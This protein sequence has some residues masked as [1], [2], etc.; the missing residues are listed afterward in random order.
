MLAIVLFAVRR[1]IKNRNDHNTTS[2]DKNKNKKEVSEENTDDQDQEDV[3][4]SVTPPHHE[5]SDKLVQIEAGPWH[6]QGDV[7][8]G[9]IKTR[10]EDLQYKCVQG[11]N[12][13]PV[14]RKGRRFKI[15]N[16][17]EG[18]WVFSLSADAG[19]TWIRFGS[20]SSRGGTYG[21]PSATLDSD[22]PFFME[23][24]VDDDF[25]FG[26]EGPDGMPPD[27]KYFYCEARL[28]SKFDT[29]Y[30]AIPLIDGKGIPG[31]ITALGSTEKLS[32]SGLTPGSSYKLQ[33]K[34]FDSTRVPWQTFA[35]FHV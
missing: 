16:L 3:P 21:G 28:T 30:R 32:F 4:K 25:E 10:L 29:K 8:S 33:H 9:Y 1:R 5:P 2:E 24:V 13:A 12:S 14:T 27:G 35:T 34:L 6:V 20:V 31:E 19:H 7:W 22:A 23:D 17:T 26:P 18:S 15:S 11:E